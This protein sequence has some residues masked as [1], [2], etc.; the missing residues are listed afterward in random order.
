MLYI[1]HTLPGL[2]GLAWREAE[3]LLP[4]P[5]DA[6]GAHTI[7]TRF[8]P[9]RNDML[10]VDYKGTAKALTRLRISEDA[11]AMAARAF[12]IAP[13]AR[14]LRQIHAAVRSSSTYGNAIAAWSRTAGRGNR[15]QTFRVVAR[16]VGK[17]K[18]MRREIGKAVADAIGD[19]WNLRWRQVD[20]NADVEI[21]ATLLQDELIC[22][23]RLSGA[24]MRQRGKLKH[25]PASLRPALAAA[26]V[27]LSRPE[28]S[29]VFLDPMAGAGTLLV[30]RAAAGPFRAIYGGDINKEAVNAMRENAYGIKGDVTMQQWDVRKLP[31]DDAS[32]TK[33]VVNLPFG[34][35]IA[36]ETVIPGLYQAAL[37]E[38]QRVLRPGGRLI[39]L[40]AD[41]RLVDEARR[42]T[43]RNLR[44]QQRH[45]LVVLGQAATIGEYIRGE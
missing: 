27:M 38:I 25:L 7:G 11:F 22:A 26:M 14:G 32:V 42:L 33:V 30:E 20:D 29:D 6:P 41:G 9:G 31:L 43:A 17:H 28:P 10:L 35:Q 12:K 37:G 24:E 3:T 8:V 1:L 18:F 5:E 19:G 15:P 16:E 4:V 44:P 21:W 34:R 39:T 2:A 13:D 40:S 45:K 23:V 36:D